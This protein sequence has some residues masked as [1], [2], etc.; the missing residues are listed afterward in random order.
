MDTAALTRET[1]T[2][3]TTDGAGRLLALAGA[4]FAVLQVAGD[5]TIGEFPGG[6]TGPARL[7]AYYAMHHAQVATG[8]LLLGLSALFLGLFGA[9][10][11]CRVRTGAH[12]VALG[13]VVL[14]GAAIEAS[15]Q[16][17]SAATYSLLGQFS[18]DQNLTPAAL[19]AWHLAGAEFGPGTGST[20]LLLAVAT[21][22]ILAR[23]VPAWLA[24]PALLLGIA[25][26]SPFGFLASL[27]FL[28]WSLVA[29]VA[30]A[31]RGRAV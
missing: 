4:G 15:Q 28:L 10:L 1:L 24:W 30:L 18:T 26:L 7:T 21:A 13:A 2:T 3:R 5:L 8:G 19:Q 22:G 14:I 31:V 27:A 11:Y 23:A 20:L 6:Q 9:G 12:G 16:A 17:G 25:T 29:G